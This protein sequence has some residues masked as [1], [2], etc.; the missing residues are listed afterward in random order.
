MSDLLTAAKHILDNAIDSG[1]YGP[2]DVLDLD[3]E[4]PRDKDG[5]VWYHDFWELKEAIDKIEST[6]RQE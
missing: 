5:N 3:I 6:Q 1:A 2:D 4:W